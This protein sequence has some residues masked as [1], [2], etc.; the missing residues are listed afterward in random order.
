MLTALDYYVLIIDVRNLA[1][2]LNNRA[3][4]SIPLSD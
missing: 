1:L 2:T 3:V 4:Y